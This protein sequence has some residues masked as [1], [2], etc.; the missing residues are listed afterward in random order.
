MFGDGSPLT[1]TIPT[2]DLPGTN[3]LIVQHSMSSGSSNDATNLSFRQDPNDEVPTKTV[4]SPLPSFSDTKGSGISPRPSPVLTNVTRSSN[5]ANLT[6]LT[7][8]ARARKKKKAGA[9][10]EPQQGNSSPS[11]PD[12]SV[13]RLLEEKR[14]AFG[15]ISRHATVNPHKTINYAILKKFVLTVKVREGSQ[16]KMDQRL[17]V[18]SLLFVSVIHYPLTE[19]RPLCKRCKAVAA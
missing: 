3:N 19:I 18:H 10:D 5:K 17:R 4:D 15:V 6:P 11:S 7:T 13:L 16:E 14:S 2:T 12:K 9:E 1:T 8:P